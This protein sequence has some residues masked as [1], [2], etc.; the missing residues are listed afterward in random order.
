MFI[1]FGNKKT[2]T[3]LFSVMAYYN[4]YKSKVLCTLYMYNPVGMNIDNHKH[5]SCLTTKKKKNAHGT[6]PFLDVST[7]C[8]VGKVE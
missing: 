8:I 5:S 4:L 3:H 2:T 1:Q 6:F 7:E